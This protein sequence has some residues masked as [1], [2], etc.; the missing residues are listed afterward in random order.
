VDE[1]IASPR[2]LTGKYLSGELSIAIP[3]SRLKP[4]KERGWLEVLGAS[5]NNLKHIDFKIPVGLMTCVTGG[6][7]ARVKAT[8]VDDILRRALFR[9]YYGSK[10]RPGAHRELKGHD[11]FDKVIVVD[12]TPIGRTPGAIRPPT[13]GSSTRSATCLRGCPPPKS[14]GMERDGSALTSRVG[15]AKNAKVTA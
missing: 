8:A 7:A 13:R 5:E 15:D 1:I 4:S 14:G 10:E 9:L 6:L 12:Q 3:K 11:L 2:S